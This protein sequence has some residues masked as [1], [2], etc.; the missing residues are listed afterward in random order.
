M[1]DEILRMLRENDAR[2]GITEVKE[3]PPL[4]LP[5]AQRLLNPFPLAQSGQGWGDSGQPWAANILIFYASVF[6]V[7]TNNGTNFWT[8]TLTDDTNTIR[9]TI[10]TSGIAANGWHRLSAVPAS[11]P[12]AG[13]SVLS[14]T[15]T[16]TL[17][18]GA[19][20]IAPAVALLRTGN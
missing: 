19:I 7:T 6:V 12:A 11:Q 20:Y 10:V 13:N 15:A 18:P 3:V 17:T 9:A 16:A 5:W 2:M 14:I 4:Y 8:L 1:S